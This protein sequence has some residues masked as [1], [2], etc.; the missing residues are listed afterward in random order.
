MDDR[1]QEKPFAYIGV[2]LYTVQCTVS[3]V[4]TVYMWV[5]VFGYC[6]NL[7]LFT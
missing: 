5:M 7:S 4:Y 3:N 2:Q 1:K 6:E